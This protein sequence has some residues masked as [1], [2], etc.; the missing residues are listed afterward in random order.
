LI[1][2]GPAAGVDNGGGVAD[3]IFPSNP[4]AEMWSSGSAALLSATNGSSVGNKPNSTNFLV[5]WD[6]DESRELEDGTSITKYGGSTLLSCAECA[7]NNGAQSTPT[8]TADLLGD[9]REEI[10]W[11]EADNTG[12]R[13]HAPDL[14]PDAR[15]AVPHAGNLR[16]DRV[17]STA[18]CRLPHRQ[19]HGASAPARHLPV[20]AHAS[21]PS[22]FRNF[23]SVTA[24]PW[25]GFV[26]LWRC[27]CQLLFS[28]YLRP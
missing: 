23:L 2:K 5:Y 11:R 20:I 28:W 3:D 25:V 24:R 17:Q 13:D 4:G 21:A 6:A 1:V 12:L 26:Q 16:A 9:W 7:S 10:I 27:R 18:A 15:S 19:R 14:H 22:H 8:L